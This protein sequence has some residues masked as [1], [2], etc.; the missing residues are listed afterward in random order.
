MKLFSKMQVV[1]NA[2]ERTLREMVSLAASAGWKIIKVTRTSGS[3]FGYMVAIPVAIPEKEFISDPAIPD[4]SSASA[5]ATSI[6]M[7]NFKLKHSEQK[8]GSELEVIERASSRCGTPTFGSN[9][10]L[11]SIQE[12]M[13]RFGGGIARRPRGM[14]ST[15]P[16]SSSVSHEP[17]PVPLKP[18]LL[19]SGSRGK[20]KKNKPLPLSIVPSQAS[21]TSPAHS[22]TMLQTPSSATIFPAG[23]MSVPSSQLN[24]S[25]GPRKS[26]P[27][28]LSMA[29]LRPTTSHSQQPP[30][31]PTLTRHPPPSPPSPRNPNLTIPPSPARMPTR[32]ASQAQLSQ[33][34][35]VAVSHFREVVPGILSQSCIPKRASVIQT[36]LNSSLPSLSGHS[37]ATSPDSSLA[38]VPPLVAQRTIQR[39]SSYVQLP[40]VPL[41]KRSGTVVGPSV[42]PYISSGDTSWICGRSS[43]FVVVASPKPSI[44]ESPEAFRP[45]PESSLTCQSSAE[46]NS[47]EYERGN[48]LAAAARIEK[49]EFG[50]SKNH[51]DG[52]QSPPP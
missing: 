36:K 4:P 20:A 29:N 22:S 40:Q 24:H 21:S 28:R 10:R 14:I 9:M 18:A 33:S 17:P 43:E 45:P 11:S 19:L 46:G 34:A 35:E 48:V 2:Q 47:F 38:L 1:F 41:R 31:L 16:P 15:Y 5:R 37:I 44:G 26:V 6:S 23:G 25:P 3:L 51:H 50:W 27:R 32:R 12:T 39:R 49:G 13:T 30:P 8:K 52:V 7:E 42:N